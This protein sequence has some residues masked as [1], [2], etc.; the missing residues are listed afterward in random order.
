MT[1]RRTHLV[2]VL[3]FVVAVALHAQGMLDPSKP[4]VQMISVE[5]DV[6]LEVL[7][8]GGIGRNLVLLAGLGDNAHIF[9]QF[10]PK[11]ATTY[12]VYAITCRGRGASSKPPSNELNYR[13]DRL[14]E[15]VV[16]VIDALHLREPVIAGH[17]LSGEELSYIGSNHPEK[18]AGLFYM[19]AGYPAP[20][21]ANCQPA[22]PIV[23]HPS[24]GESP[25]LDR[26]SRSRNPLPRTPGF[27]LPPTAD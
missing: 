12:H 21:K 16:A 3:S 4:T 18:I 25:L 19:E 20:R 27:G 13:A 8:W 22:Y 2:F 11:L 17:S 23:W 26:R 9:D 10:A 7:D 5:R 14:G 24:R 6:R 15:D 1:I